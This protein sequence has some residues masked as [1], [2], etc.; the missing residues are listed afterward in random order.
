MVEKEARGQELRMEQMREWRGSTFRALG[1]AA[2]QGRERETE[3]PRSRS[4]HV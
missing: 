4:S 3:G 2:G 1:E